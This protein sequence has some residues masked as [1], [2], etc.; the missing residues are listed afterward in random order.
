MYEQPQLPLDNF[1]APQE[2]LDAEER[3]FFDAEIQRRERED[4]ERAYAAKDMR[5]SYERAAA[6]GARRQGPHSATE[7]Q[8]AFLTK[9]SGERDWSHLGPDEPVA[10]TIRAALRHTW[11]DKV[12]ASQAI[13]ELLKI[14]PKSTDAGGRKPMGTLPA[15][16]F[17]LQGS[18]GIVRFYS[19][20][21]GNKDTR[22]E[23]YTFISQLSGAPG[24]YVEHKMPKSERDRI[25]AELGR[26]ISAAA[27]LYAT[28]T[29]R[30][31]FCESPLTDVRS[32]AAGWGETCAGKHGMPYPSLR[33]AQELLGETGTE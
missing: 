25:A 30:C 21:H 9:L 4:D 26:D 24:S 13:N 31:S 11:V 10:L 14:R 32:R 18:D 15:G 22:W 17:A 27:R 19:V 5:D 33:A 7:K 28:K 16:R 20:R 3:A 8:L 23:G 12:E 1:H 6:V 29:E 2:D